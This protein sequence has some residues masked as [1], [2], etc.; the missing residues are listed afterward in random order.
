MFLPQAHTLSP[1]TCSPRPKEILYNFGSSME[2]S[3]MACD[4]Q[5]S[6][7]AQLLLASEPS[8]LCPASVQKGHL[9]PWGREACSL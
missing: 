4:L 7:L 8:L 5:W 9:L 2:G 6:P 1:T 3:A